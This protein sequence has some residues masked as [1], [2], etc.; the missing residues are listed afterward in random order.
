MCFCLR[1]FT[2][3]SPRLGYSFDV[4]MSSTLPFVLG[5]SRSLNTRPFIHLPFY[6]QSPAQYTQKVRAMSAQNQKSYHRQPTGL[7]ATTAANHS[8]EADLKLYGSCFWW[9]LS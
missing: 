9:V 6:S 5:R 1:H 8:K 7:A 2:S 3:N 4:G